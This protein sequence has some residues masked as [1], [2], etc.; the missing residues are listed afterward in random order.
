[1]RFYFEVL[2][3]NLLSDLAYPIEMIGFFARKLVG[4]GFLILFWIAVS[5]NNSQIFDFNNMISYFLVSQ[6]V[7]DL[8]FSAG[9]GFGRKIQKMIKSGEF[10]N[11]L[12]KPVNILRFLFSTYVGESTISTIY[13]LVTLVIGII[14]I[15]P[16]PAINFLLF[17]ITLFFTTLTGV[18]VNILMG[19]VGF[20]I[21]ETSSFHNIFEHISKILSGK[22]IPLDYFPATIKLFA[23]LSPFPVLIYYPTIIL[24]KGALNEDTFFKI[25]L[26]IFWAFFL[27]LLS[28]IL[29]RRALKS[30]DGVGL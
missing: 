17:L 6:A 2:K 28:N 23:G 13:A 25:G 26:C 8:T 20:Y 9:T 1:M 29:W 7:S 4:L 24:Q 30:Y 11:Y 27:I 15:P 22:L 12:I 3:F 5:Q 10:S 21:P 19:T 18:G 16:L 14:I